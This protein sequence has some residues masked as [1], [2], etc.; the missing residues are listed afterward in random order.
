VYRRRLSLSSNQIVTGWDMI[1]AP[2][3]VNA[4]SV[5][6]SRSSALSCSTALAEIGRKPVMW[7]RLLSGMRLTSPS[8]SL[9]GQFEITEHST[10]NPG[11]NGHAHRKETH[12][13]THIF[14]NNRFGNYQ[15][16]TAL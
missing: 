4:A 13:W 10:F 7:E 9:H 3:S 6:K 2:A 8:E 12:E 1:T 11:F 15:E 16:T 5:T 14:T